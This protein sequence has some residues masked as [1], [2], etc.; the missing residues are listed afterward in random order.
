MDVYSDEDQLVLTYK[1]WMRLTNLKFLLIPMPFVCIVVFFL[2]I[3]ESWIFPWYDLAFE[4]C[5]PLHLRWFCFISLWAY[6][7]FSIMIADQIYNREV[8]RESDSFLPVP[9]Y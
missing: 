5:F 4:D 7:V 2:S 8:L 1:G 6:L 9:D 3:N